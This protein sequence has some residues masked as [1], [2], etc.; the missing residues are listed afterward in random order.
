[1]SVRRSGTL[2]IKKVLRFNKRLV[3]SD[4]DLPHT[5]P[6]EHHRLGE[7]C[8]RQTVS[9]GSLFLRTSIDS[10]SDTESETE[11]ESDSS[12]VGGFLGQ[13][14]EVLKEIDK[15]Q[16]DLDRVLNG[17]R[18]L[19]VGDRLRRKAAHRS[20]VHRLHNAKEV[21]ELMET[22]GEMERKLSEVEVS[23]EKIRRQRDKCHKTMVKWSIAHGKTLEQL[24]SKELDL[25]KLKR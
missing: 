10:D 23:R 21:L 20:A 12:D 22:K 25:I 16:R 14:D 17:D 15:A 4:S 2:R 24:H 13:R 7:V 9:D 19:T 5:P 11:S 3:R 6:K 8:S 18:P 1:M